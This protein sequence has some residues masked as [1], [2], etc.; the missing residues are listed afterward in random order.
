MSS[1]IIE[2]SRSESSVIS[3]SKVFK[4]EILELRML[5]RFSVVGR[6]LAELSSTTWLN[7][8][9][10]FSDLVADKFEEPRARLRELSPHVHFS[11]NIFLRLCVLRLSSF[12]LN[13]LR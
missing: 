13:L 11:A 6:F 8:R 9:P 12:F 2:H 4:S 3:S 10:S 7:E 5:D 1:L